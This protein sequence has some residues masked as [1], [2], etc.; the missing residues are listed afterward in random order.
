MSSESFSDNDG[1]SFHINCDDFSSEETD[2]SSDSDSDSTKE[3]DVNCSSNNNCASCDESNLFNT[4]HM[5]GSLMMFPRAQLTIAD[6]LLM[7]TVYSIKKRLTKK[8]ENDLIELVKLLAGPEF[9]SWNPSQHARDKAYN[10]PKSKINTHFYCT[11]CNIILTSHNCKRMK[12]KSIKC[13][14]CETQYNLTLE[15]PNQFILIDFEYQLKILLHEEDVQKDLLQTL[16]KI[17]ESQNNGVIND[18][19]DSKL[20]KNIQGSSPQTLTYNLNTDGAPAF[21]SSN[22]SFWPIQLHLNELSPRIRKQNI[23]LAGMFLTSSEP[24]PEL[25]KIYLSK[26]IDDAEKLMK[27]GLNITIHNSNEQKNF[28][29]HC[30]LVCVDSVARPVIQ[31]RYQFNGYYGCSWCYAHGEYYNSAMR[32]PIVEN[33]PALRTHNDHVLDIE[34]GEKLSRHINGVKGRTELLRLKHLDCVWSLPVDYMHGV[35][36]GVSRQLWSIWT[37]PKTPYYLTSKNRE[38]I[39]KRYLSIKRPH[40]I[41]RLTRS[42][43]TMA[44]WKASEWESWLLF[45]SLPCLDGILKKSALIHIVYLCLAFINFYLGI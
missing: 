4:D 3:N 35:L 40:E 14:D 25:M 43:K 41:H 17:S 31:N 33:D 22:R 34:N 36:L 21:K 1:S 6:V 16:T 18:I 37:T 45:D 44:K 11:N 5:Q 12:T 38:E 42:I 32:Y 24:S 15:S 7:I 13:T 8:D 19:Y 39:D 28:K 29:F 27:N 10:P 23:I 26:F 20:Y 30:L 2:F 9:S